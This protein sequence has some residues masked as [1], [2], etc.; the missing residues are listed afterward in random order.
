MPLEATPGAPTANSY[1]TRAEFRTYHAAHVAFEASEDLEDDAVDRALQ[2]ATRQIEAYVTWRGWA[3][4]PTVQVLAFP[5]TGLYDPNTAA[6]VASNTIPQRL[7]DA[8]CEQ[9]R[10]LLASDRSLETSQGQQGLRRLKAG[11]VDLEFDATVAGGVLQTI[12]PSA[13]QFIACWGLLI[14]QGQGGA[15]PLS[16]TYR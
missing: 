1:A 8:C 2:Q 15:I 5:R 16:R 9:A 10:L 6:P 14:Q 7:K 11:S 3:T 13:W 4:S 12:A